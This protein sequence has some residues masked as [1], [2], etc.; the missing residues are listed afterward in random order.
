VGIGG[1]I[2][3]LVLA[4][5]GLAHTPGLSVAE[6]DVGPDGR[7]DATFTF[8]SAEPLAGTPLRDDDLR[9]F[10]LDGVDVTADGARC[11]PTFEGARPTEADG[12]ELDAT[13]A[14]APGAADLTVTLYYLTA[15]RPGH[16]EIARLVAPHATA[17]AILSAD[18]RALNLHVPG[19]PGARRAVDRR[20]VVGLAG[21]GGI[22][23]LGAAV[24]WR[25]RSRLRVS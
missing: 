17:E 6:L 24:A 20:L 2:A 13:Y 15:L 11:E 12:L 18:H 1:V 25:R 16:R 5:P 14:C 7:V 9:A 21:L 10:L 23:A 4:R 3:T 19:A 8:A 22:A